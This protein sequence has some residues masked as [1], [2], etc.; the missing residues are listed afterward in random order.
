M[1]AYICTVL[2]LGLIVT[3]CANGPQSAEKPAPDRSTYLSKAERLDAVALLPPPP[4]PDSAA[5]RLDEARN[6]QYRQN[7]TDERWQQAALDARIRLPEA[8]G[9]FDCAT[10]IALSEGAA[11][12]TVS[13]LRRVS[14][15]TVMAVI[16]AKKKY[17]RQRPFMLNNEAICTPDAIRQLQRD[18]SYPS[19]HAAAGWAWALVLAELIPDKADEILQ[20]GRQFGLSR[21]ICN[22]HWPS[23]VEQGQLLASALVARLHGSSAFQADI[24]TAKQELAALPEATGPVG[25]CAR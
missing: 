9:A 3:G 11:P 2:L 18:G 22:V 7:T 14:I 16:P 20:R 1:H 23:D 21:A 12:H 5:Q 15:D 17:R 4:A 10:R 24:A 13:I 25:E 8:A 19:G 6:Q